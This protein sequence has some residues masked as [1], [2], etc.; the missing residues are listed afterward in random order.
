MSIWSYQHHCWKSNATKI[1]SGALKPTIKKVMFRSRSPFVH[2]G[3]YIDREYILKK[4]IRPRENRERENIPLTAH[5][6]H[7]ISQSHQPKTSP[8]S[9]LTLH[10]HVTVF[11]NTHSSHRYCYHHVCIQSIYNHKKKQKPTSKW[12][13][14]HHPSWTLRWKPSCM[15]RRTSIKHVPSAIKGLANRRRTITRLWC[16]SSSHI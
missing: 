7:I 11:T 6:S 15:A 2:R 16:Q 13:K 1:R 4:I 12:P 14:I 5:R 8:A 3:Y 9:D 10:R